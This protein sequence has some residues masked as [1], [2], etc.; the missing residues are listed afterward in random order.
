M[1]QRVIGKTGAGINCAFAGM[2]DYR[3]FCAALN[4]WYEK[5]ESRKAQIR[6][7]LDELAD[8]RQKAVRELGKANRLTRRLS[9]LQRKEMGFLISP[10]A[11][12]YEPSRKAGNMPDISP[13]PRP[14]APE[15][16]RNLRELKAGELA[17][18]SMVEGL[19]K[20]L[21]QLDLLEMRC[22]E[23]LLSIA[24][25]MKVYNHE[26]LCAKRRIYPLSLASMFFKS[27]KTLLG[28]AYYSKGDLK[29]LTVLGNLAVNIVRIAESPLV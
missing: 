6:L 27:L 8:L 5:Y 23:L 22:R 29:E 15:E 11:P 17:V 26:Y 21:L 13:K 1:E 7:L 4:E 18:L 14:C 10:K 9:A 25:A 3:L 12:S 16:F 19:K 2:G 24:K 28:R 20:N